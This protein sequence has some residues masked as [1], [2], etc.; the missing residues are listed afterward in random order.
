MEFFERVNDVR[1]KRRVIISPMIEP[2]AEE[3]IQTYS[4]EAYTYPKKI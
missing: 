3:V 4:I 2:K 1:V